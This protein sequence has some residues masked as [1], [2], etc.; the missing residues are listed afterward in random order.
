MNMTNTELKE[1]VSKIEQLLKSD[2]PEAGFEL[3]KTI[4]EPE[5]NEAVA[6]LIQSTVYK[7][8]FEEQSEQK[9][10]DEGLKILKKLLPNLNSLDMCAC[11]MQKLDISEFVNLVSLDLSYCDSLEKIIGLEKLE[12]LVDLDLSYTSSLKN[13]DIDELKNLEKVIG[14]RNIYGMVVDGKLEA[15]YWEYLDEYLD[16]E[17]QQILE[18]NDENVEDYLGSNINVLIEESDFYDGSFQSNRYFFKPLENYLSK[19][20]MECLPTVGEDEV[21]VFL[22]HDGWDFITSFHRDKD[23]FPGEDEFLEP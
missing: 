22:F 20:Q 4:N 2:K 8:C 18:N 1:N 5:L 7:K 19:K 13:L 10:V 17:F 11:Y 15:D 6:D 16:N 14:L 9:I 12:K 23:D 21:A 3:L